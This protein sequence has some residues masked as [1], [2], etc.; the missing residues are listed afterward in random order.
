MAEE[1]AIYDTTIIMLSTMHG[2]EVPTR[3]AYTGPD[4]MSIKQRYDRCTTSPVVAAFEKR[5]SNLYETLKRTTLFAPE[6]AALFSNNG[7][8]IERERHR[9]W[10]PAGVQ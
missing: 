1:F 7:L 9:Q 5:E 6:N 10:W 3:T 4:P 8:M 2:S